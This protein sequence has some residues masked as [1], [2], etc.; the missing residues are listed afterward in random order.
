MSCVQGSFDS[1]ARAEVTW[2]LR[3]LMWCCLLIFSSSVVLRWREVQMIGARRRRR[4]SC[5]PAKIR[6]A[7]VARM[8]QRRSVSVYVNTKRLDRSAC[9]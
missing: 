6:V 1:G 5:V 7:H 8:I 4:S 9:V 3:F 2:R